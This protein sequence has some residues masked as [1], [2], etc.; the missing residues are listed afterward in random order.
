MQCPRCGAISA[1]DA[2][3]L[4]CSNCGV[5][6]NE[7]TSPAPSLLNGEASGLPTVQENSWQENAPVASPLPFA[8]QLPGNE[9]ALPATPP[10]VSG[11][12]YMDT[13]WAEFS[14]A[15][16]STPIPESSGATSLPL[17]PAPGG[18]VSPG[19][20]PYM[21][22]T[23]LPGLMPPA[24]KRRRPAMT[25]ILSILVVLLVGG[26]V[27]VGI[28]IGQA[29]SGAPSSQAATTPTA[30]PTPNV[31]QLYQQITSQTPTFTDSLQDASLSQWSV[32]EKPTYGCEIKNDGLHVHIS[33]NGHFTYCTT[34]RGQFSDFAF[35][36][37]MKILLNPELSG[38]TISSFASG[39]G[40]KNLLTVIAQGSVLDFYVNQQLLVTLQDSTYTS[41][42]LGVLADDHDAPADVVYT[43][44]KLWVL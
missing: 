25:I 6:L 1:N 34:G 2:N 14:G 31:V 12:P 32:F 3:T 9:A 44:A 17:S 4:Y 26:G 38:G 18:Y 35:Q 33:D 37:E 39:F 11:G 13:G 21:P 43:N 5:P 29:R 10:P 24:P 42:Y 20:Y 27:F 36:V 30:S 22:D 40:Q 8:Q 41:G 15:S 28:Y 23:V 7:G 16:A 19:N